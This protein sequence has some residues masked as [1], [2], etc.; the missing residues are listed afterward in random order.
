MKGKQGE[1][2]NGHVILSRDAAKE[3]ALD[4]A[5]LRG[6]LASLSERFEKAIYSEG[7]IK[8]GRSKSNG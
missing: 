5:K 3:I 2:G 8:L 1:V 4:L 6:D 7:Q